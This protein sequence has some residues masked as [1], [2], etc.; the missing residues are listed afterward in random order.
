[1]FYTAGLLPAEVGYITDRNL[2]LVKKAPGKGISESSLKKLNP[3]LWRK[4]Y[5]PGSINAKIKEKIEKL[6][7]K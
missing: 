3:K 6:S 2:K 5:G 1:M 4:L 7:K